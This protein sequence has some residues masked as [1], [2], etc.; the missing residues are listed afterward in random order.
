[1]IPILIK[2]TQQ[3]STRAMRTIVSQ[4]QKTS[5]HNMGTWMHQVATPKRFT[6][7]HAREANYTPRK[8]RYEAKKYKLYQ[9]KDPLRFTGRARLASTMARITATA[10]KVTIRY[11]QMRVLN[12]KLKNSTINM[13]QEF[14][15]V[16]QNEQVELSNVF[17]NSMEL[18][19]QRAGIGRKGSWVSGPSDPEITYAR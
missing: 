4:A 13:R 10:S 6:R 9:H 7:E 1:M 12:L 17:E 15:T 11:P 19:I 2:R 5:N 8:K 3:V 14:E 18:S 16:T